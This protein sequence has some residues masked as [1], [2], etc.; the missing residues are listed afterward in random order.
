[1]NE[2]LIKVCRYYKGEDKCP[3]DNSKGDNTPFMLWHGERAFVYMTIDNQSTSKMLKTYNYYV[4]DKLKCDVY[5]RYYNAVL[6]NMY[7]KTVWSTESA[8]T[9][10][11]KFNKQY[12]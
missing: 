5:E 7:C 10:F 4:G 12:Y 11:I 2:D 6:F 3:F 1:M 8:V 9:G